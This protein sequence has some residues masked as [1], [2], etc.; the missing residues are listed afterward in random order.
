MK[1][2]G[3]RHLPKVSD[4]DVSPADEARLFQRFRWNQWSP[5][6]NLERYGFFWR[7]VARNG[8]A[9]G[10]SWGFGAVR[11]F[12]PFILAAFAAAYILVR[13]FG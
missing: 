9:R 12:G 6:G 2:P 5:A 11:M 1:R 10:W 3:R 4:D 13:L 8:T 7:Q